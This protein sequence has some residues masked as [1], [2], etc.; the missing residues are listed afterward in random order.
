MQFRKFGTH[1][2]GQWGDTINDPAART[3]ALNYDDKKYSGC[4]NGKYLKP[5]TCK[6]LPGK[7]VT[8][9]IKRKGWYSISCLFG[10]LAREDL[11]ITTITNDVPGASVYQKGS[12]RADPGTISSCDRFTLTPDE[13]TYVLDLWLL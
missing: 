4:I 13:P 10:M 8:W 12:G 1:I 11:T 6:D 2:S 7:S 5:A 3:L 9:E